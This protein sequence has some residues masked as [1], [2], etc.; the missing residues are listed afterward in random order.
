MILNNVIVRLGFDALKE[1]QKV[2]ILSFLSG[3]DVF[4]SL[5]MGYGKSLCYGCLPWVYN[6]LKQRSTSIALI[7]SPLFALMNDQVDIF[8]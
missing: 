1:E 3:K 5:P 7:V 2:T 4:I 6:S 8:G